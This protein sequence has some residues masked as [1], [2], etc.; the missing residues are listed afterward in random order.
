LKRYPGVSYFLFFKSRLEWHW[1]FKYL[2]S[3]PDN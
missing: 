1:I 2:V 3:I